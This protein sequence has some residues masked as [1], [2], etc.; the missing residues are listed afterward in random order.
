VAFLYGDPVSDAERSDLLRRLR[1]RGT[2]E[3][4]LAA[5]TIAHS[6]R[7]ATSD[8]AS[9]ARTAILY[10][11]EQWPRLDETNPRLATVRDRLSNPAK[12]TRVI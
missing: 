7:D 11:L 9:E 3:S 5:S 12:A 6:R 4:L 1:E 10:E 2:T 8:T